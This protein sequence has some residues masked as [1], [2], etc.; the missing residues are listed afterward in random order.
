V[1]LISLNHVKISKPVTSFANSLARDS[2][3][4][5]F[6][7]SVHEYSRERCKHSRQCE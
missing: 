1:N 3:Q 5:V 2:E 7:M 4:V 6:T